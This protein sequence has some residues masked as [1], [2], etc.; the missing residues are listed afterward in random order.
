MGRLDILLLLLSEHVK[1]KKKKRFE[2]NYVF[3]PGEKKGEENPA[4]TTTA[5]IHHWS[6]EKSGCHKNRT[7]CVGR[8]FSF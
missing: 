4:P 5:Q 7:V 1:K 6:V 8:G 3:P 2:V